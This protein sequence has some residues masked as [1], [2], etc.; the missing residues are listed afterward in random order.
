MSKRE[1]ADVEIADAPAP[2][3]AF[4]AILHNPAMSAIIRHVSDI[5][6]GRLLRISWAVRRR[7]IDVL[8]YVR[9]SSWDKWLLC[10]IKFMAGTNLDRIR[11]VFAQTTNFAP[12]MIRAIAQSNCIN[13]HR[14]FGRRLGRIEQPGVEKS[15]RDA[16]Y[17][18]YIRTMIESSN[19]SALL[20]ADNHDGTIW[21]LSKSTIINWV[22][23]LSRVDL[24]MR[25]LSHP[26]WID[27]HSTI[28]E[29]VLKLI[30]KSA[31]VV[32]PPLSAEKQHQEWINKWQAVNIGLYL[33]K[34]CDVPIP[35]STVAAI[36]NVCGDA[37][38]LVSENLTE[39]NTVLEYYRDAPLSIPT[40]VLLQN[41][42]FHKSS[43]CIPCFRNSLQCGIFELCE[44]YFT[45]CANAQNLIA[46][47]QNVITLRFDQFLPY[48]KTLFVQKLPKDKDH[49]FLRRILDNMLTSKL[50]SVSDNIIMDEY[51]PERCKKYKCAEEY[52]THFHQLGATFVDAVTDK[53][54]HGMI[55]TQSNYR[56][57]SRN[58][59]L[60]LYAD[61][62][63]KPTVEQRNYVV[64]CAEK[65][66]TAKQD[67]KPL[68]DY[69]EKH[70][71]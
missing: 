26:L 46:Q 59:I 5:T 10:N 62:I 47:Y 9:R 2:P 60:R 8:F 31:K 67:W 27:H 69:F 68:I 45:A 4:D 32:P 22:L 37:E 53:I 38:L 33:A 30:P 15:K 16:V 14:L 17:A 34:K 52:F 51:F 61:G 48:E 43:R 36:E 55:T 13:V 66:K 28:A 57:K 70:L 64:A 54:L 63:V 23:Y 24:V 12:N 21:C 50:M 44:K 18:L 29:Q 41:G 3:G 20:L 56:V 25:M 7:T 39:Q 19:L 11:G 35:A 49:S 58:L 65:S 71:Q 6:V 40:D 1:R 42:H